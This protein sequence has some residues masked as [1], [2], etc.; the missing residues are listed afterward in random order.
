MAITQPAYVALPYNTRSRLNIS[1]DTVIKASKGYIAV[2]NVLVAG[3]AGEIH[4]C[5]T[6]AAA[7]NANR[8]AAIPATVG[9][10]VLNFPCANGIV[11]K[12]GAGQVISVSYL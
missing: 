3:A 1:A 4:D 6:V 7:A 5:A 11:Y 8:V 9:I 2:V 12:V 10:H